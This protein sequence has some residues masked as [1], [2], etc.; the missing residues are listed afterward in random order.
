MEKGRV[1]AALSP[2]ITV[3]AW[4]Q[5]NPFR[6]VQLDEE[7]AMLARTLPFNHDDPADRFIAATSYRLMC[8]LATV[9]DR[10]RKLEWL[11][12]FG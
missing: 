4:L 8:P 9:D 12:V 3:R 2:E 6:I 5:G 7:I 1:T 11:N 10:L